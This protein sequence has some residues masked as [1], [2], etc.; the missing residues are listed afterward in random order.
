M[1]ETLDVTVRDYINDLINEIKTDYEQQISSLKTNAI[2][3]QNKYLEIK[4]RYDLLIYKRF[5]RSAE[6]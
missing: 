5:S 6:E 4:E 3:Y 1:L 2:E